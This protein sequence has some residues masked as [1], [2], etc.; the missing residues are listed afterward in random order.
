[1]A[2][3]DL[4]TGEALL[5]IDIPANSPC[6]ASEWPGILAF[7]GAF[8]YLGVGCREQATLVV[9]DVGSGEVVDTGLKVP[10][11]AV[12]RD[13]VAYLVGRALEPSGDVFRVAFQASAVDLVS[14]ST[15]WAWRVDVEPPSYYERGSVPVGISLVGPGDVVAVYAEEFSRPE[16]GAWTVYYAVVTADAGGITARYYPVPASS[17]AAEDLQIGGHEMAVGE[18][19]LYLLHFLLGREAGTLALQ[20]LDLTNGHLYTTE[21][22]VTHPDW[23]DPEVYLI[24]DIRSQRPVVA[25]KTAAAGGGVLHLALYGKQAEQVAARAVQWPITARPFGVVDG[26]FYYGDKPDSNLLVMG[27]P[28]ASPQPSQVVAV[29][30]VENPWE[31]LGRLLTGA[32]GIGFFMGGRSGSGAVEVTGESLY[33]V[34]P[35]GREALKVNLECMIPGSCF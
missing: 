28:L 12:Y 4:N 35:S 31:V 21:I 3:V 9:V 34:L 25:Y 26:V 7:D 10:E 23:N 32:M 30:P 16:G 27:V 8:V 5:A 13:G 22:P 33:I 19:T 1:M 18:G 20:A 14:G 24:V 29:I 11:T 17:P 15:L 2:V 6:D